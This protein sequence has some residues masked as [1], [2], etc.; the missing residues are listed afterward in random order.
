MDHICRK[1]HRRRNPPSTNNDTQLA[2]TKRAL[3]RT[4]KRKHKHSQQTGD[5]PKG[6]PAKLKAKKK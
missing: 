5:K 1:A 3:A 4:E 6:P 2:M